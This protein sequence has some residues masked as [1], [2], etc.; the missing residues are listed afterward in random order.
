MLFEKFTYACYIESVKEILKDHQQ[1]AFDGVLQGKYLILR[2]DV[3][4]DLDKA[5]EL[6][7]IEREHGI[8]ATYFLMVNSDM[9][10]VFNSN[11]VKELWVMGHK[12]GLHYDLSKNDDVYRQAEMLSIHG[13]VNVNTI[14]AHNPSISGKDK[15]ASGKWHNSAY[16][17]KYTK[18][19]TYIS[20]SCGHW[21][22]GAWDN[23]PDRIQLNTHPI[24]WSVMETGRYQK[25]ESIR[26]KKLGEVN[27][28]MDYCV[29]LWHK[30]DEVNSER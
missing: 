15:W 7:L 12:V 29:E 27:Y 3:D 20:D 30:H 19:T 26:Q 21:R 5:L 6:A 25:L 28:Y 24:N 9:Y 14:A 18:D 22:K 2:H 23:I 11:I 8:H 10:N 4:Y 13:G 1:V 16:A 17:D